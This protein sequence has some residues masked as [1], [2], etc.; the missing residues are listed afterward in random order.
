MGLVQK[1]FG[2]RVPGLERYSVHVGEWTQ[3]HVLCTHRVAA[4]L[5]GGLGLHALLALEGNPC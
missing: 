3:E 2:G 1:G 4:L 5:N